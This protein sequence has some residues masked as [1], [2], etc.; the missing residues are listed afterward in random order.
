[1]SSCLLRPSEGVWC[2]GSNTNGR[3]GDGSTTARLVPTN[4]T[5]L[6]ATPIQISNG[7]AHV[8]VLLSTGGVRCWGDNSNYQMGDGT[9]S[10][11]LTPSNVLTLAGVTHVACGGYHGC[12]LL[13]TGNVKCWGSNS[14]GQLGDGTTSNRNTPTDV[15]GL[16]GVVQLVGSSY[17]TCA[18]TAS[19]GVKCWGLNMYGQLGDGTNTDRLTPTNV[20]SLS[21]GVVSIS[22][23][24]FHSCAVMAYG[25]VRCWGKNDNGQL[26][27]GTTTST[28]TP[29]NVTSLSQAA[30]RLMIG[31]GSTH[32]CVVLADTTIQCWGR[33]NE[34]QLGDGTTTTPR[35]LPSTVSSV[36]GGA[37]CWR[38]LS[39]VCPAGCW[40]REVLGLQ[41]RRAGW[42]RHVHDPSHLPTDRRWDV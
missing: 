37:D 26:G 18:L 20:V 29:V 32:T 2:W 35:S 19:E 38:V 12:A 21:Q 11:R 24:L 4:V 22:A 41:L 36:S 5:G 25:G 9:I 30:T 6:A 40:W 42:R 10:T 31:Y 33:N 14:Y 1:M 13:S 39:H 17:H 28:N 15:V 23:G 7:G 34:G 8:C 3:L 16:S 27:D